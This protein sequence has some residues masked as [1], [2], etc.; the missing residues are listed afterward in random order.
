[1][2]HT[3]NPSTWEVGEEDPEFEARL[4]YIGRPCLKRNK[5]V[6]VGWECR[7][8]V[9]LDTVGDAAT[10]HRETT[11]PEEKPG[12]RA[13]NT[14]CLG[15]SAYEPGHEKGEAVANSFESGHS[16]SLGSLVSCS[17]SL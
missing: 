10:L 4:G 1:V 6:E 15:P 17:L 5:K 11:E 12:K 9:S 3:C 2:A 8:L 13:Q 7:L 14:L 16:S